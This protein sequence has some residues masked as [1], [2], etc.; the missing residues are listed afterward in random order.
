MLA[1]MTTP[2]TP[3]P[4][5]EPASAHADQAP[6]G[7]TGATRGIALVALLVAAI[8]LGLAAWGFVA[9]GT[10]Q[11]QQEA[12]DT[13]PATADIPEGWEITAQQYDIQRKTMSLLGPVIDLETGTQAVVYATI[14]CFGTGAAESVT[15]SQ[16][17]AVAAGQI[18]TERPDLG[19]Q[20]Y[21]ATDDSGSVFL[22][23]R[24]GPIVVYL[25]ASGD[26][27]AREV[28]QL[29]SAFD[30]ALGGDGG[31]ISDATSAPD[32]SDDPFASEDPFASPEPEPSEDVAVESPVVPELVASLPT[33]VG[34]LTLVA[35]SATGST[36]LS[37]DQGSRAILAALRADGL[38]VDALQVAQA[39][40]ELGASD[41]TILALRVEGMDL[42]KVNDLVFDSWLAASGAGITRTPVTLDGD[43]WT[44]L[45]YGDDLEQ[46]WVRAANGQVYVIT[47]SDPALAE[48]AAAAIP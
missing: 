32:V 10:P 36:I 24:H 23:L 38:D 12:W 30:K 14:T 27:S 29:A 13:T 41:L 17:S 31:D 3:R 37:D 45:D 22:Q 34:D 39:Y 44:L 26:T 33:Q 6:S 19:E 47:T 5:P 4:A 8:A 7:S 1:P 25:A 21:S 28:D 16:D 9:P 35:D 40:D 43:E 42:A 46:D 11:C 2:R 20:A 18:V 15:L 48:Q